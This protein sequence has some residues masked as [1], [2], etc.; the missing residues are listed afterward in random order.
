M[1]LVLERGYRKKRGMSGR[2]VALST[3]LQSLDLLGYLPLFSAFGG[4]EDVLYVTEGG[5][6]DL[7]VKNGAHR[8][9][10]ASSLRLLREKYEKGSSLVGTDWDT[11]PVYQQPALRSWRSPTFPPPSRPSRPGPAPASPDPP[12]HQGEWTPDPSPLTGQSWYHGAISRP[13]AESLVTRC[14]DFLVRD[15]AS[16][17][18]QLV[19]TAAWRGRVLHFILHAVERP[20]PAGMSP[21]LSFHLQGEGQGEGFG[22]VAELVGC[23]LQTRRPLSLASGAV[24]TRP[25]TPPCGFPS[26]GGEDNRGRCSPSAPLPPPPRLTR[27][28]GRWCG[29]QPALCGGEG[30]AGR[31]PAPSLERFGSLPAINVLPPPGSQHVRLSPSP[32]R[33]GPPGRSLGHVAGGHELGVRGGGDVQMYDQSLSEDVT[34][35]GSQS[36]LTELTCGGGGHSAGSGK[37][38]DLTGMIHNLGGVCTERSLSASVHRGPGRDL[39]TASDW[40]TQVPCPPVSQSVPVDPTPL[41]HSAPTTPT[42]GRNAAPHHHPPSFPSFSA[43]PTFGDPFGPPLPFRSAPTTPVKPDGGMAAAPS[44]FSPPPPPPS[45]PGGRRES[46]ACRAPA[47]KACSGVHSLNNHAEWSVHRGRQQPAGCKDDSR[48]C[49]DGHDSSPH[50]GYPLHPPHSPSPSPPHAGR[51]PRDNAVPS[52]TAPRA[53]ETCRDNKV[54]T[55]PYSPSLALSKSCSVQDCRGLQE[56]VSKSCSVQDSRGLQ[57]SVSKSCS[58]QDCRGLQESVSKSCSVQDCRG[59]HE[60][61]SKSCSVQD[62]RSLQESVSKSCSVQDCRGLQE[63]VSKSCSVQDCRGL[64]ESVNGWTASNPRTGFRSLPR[65]TK[66]HPRVCLT[67]HR[68]VS[69][70]GHRACCEGSVHR[71]CGPQPE[72]SVHRVCGPE[73]DGSGHVCSRPE[74]DAHVCSRPEGQTVK[75]K[76]FRQPEAKPSSSIRVEGFQCSLLPLSVSRRLDSGVLLHAKAL[77]LCSTAADLARHITS[78]DLALWRVTGDHDLGMGVTSGIELCTLPQGEQLREDAIERSECQR[79]WVMTSLLT[80]TAVKERARMLSLWI[81]VA[82]ELDVSMGNFF[83]LASIMEALTSPQVQRLSHTW[84]AVRHHHTP[85]A[86]L[87]DTRLRPLYRSLRLQGTP[88]SPLPWP[89]TLPYLTPLLRLLQAGGGGEEQ[90]PPSPAPWDLGRSLDRLLLLLHHARALAANTHLWGASARHVLAR[91]NPSGPHEAGGTGTSWTGEDEVGEDPGKDTAEEKQE[92]EETEK[93]IGKQRVMKQTENF[94]DTTHNCSQ[95]EEKGSK[96]EEEVEREESGDK[97]ERTD[98]EDKEEEKE[99]RGKEKEER[100]A[101]K[102]EGKERDEKEEEGEDSRAHQQEEMRKEK[103]RGGSRAHQQEEMRTE[104]EGGHSRAHQQE[105]ML[106]PE[107]QLKLLWGSQTSAGADRAQRVNDLEQLLTVLSHRLQPSRANNGTQL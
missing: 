18:G 45:L 33:G 104:Q 84:L 79:L 37:Q 17:P 99:E 35:T 68:T 15:S 76:P 85:S 26:E 16:Q 60:S 9:R 38:S 25:V 94:E 62:C 53:E 96:G 23:H 6:R 86:I 46:E 30:E 5:I 48:Q 75:N 64:Q 24:L 32:E 49:T 73:P 102:E 58:V 95:V 43:L 106:R 22:S 20:A 42:G 72:G 69:D 57:E 39:L 14:G 83:S 88:P 12:V 67:P 10:I 31:S 55:R 28:A 29:S 74:G 78:A 41:P 13:R 40:A 8:A 65:Q 1:T 11:V 90:D 63:S 98:K 70:P 89:L 107:F 81:D 97:K 4:V 51:T 50:P 77:M 44:P 87:F 36:D 27:R 105:E 52:C 71:V 66:L 100:E 80:C 93:E 2:H 61:V 19:L 47:P 59:L 101:G 21:R 7:G 103:E 54:D 56:S 82:R 34:P 3:W 91:I 92:E